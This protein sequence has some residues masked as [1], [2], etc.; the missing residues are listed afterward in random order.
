MRH[1]EEDKLTYNHWDSYPGGL[2]VVI[3]RAI[4]N[5]DDEHLAG[6]WARLTL[7]DDDHPPTKAD[8]ARYE[9]VA[10]LNV[11]QRSLNDWYC[12]LRNGQG[13]PERYIDGTYDHCYSGNDFLA[14]SLFCEWAY[15]INM[16]T[17]M[18]EVYEG[19]NKEGSA[20]GRYAALSAGEYAGVALV[21]EL[22]LDTIRQWTDVEVGQWAAA[23]EKIGQEENA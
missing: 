9:E 17:R 10:D 21:Q 22:P 8:Q 3:V 13:E 1:H 16:D 12:L 15:I 20:P 18:L 7:V 19:F 14:D 5:H 6:T 23:A 4:K 2:G 11:S